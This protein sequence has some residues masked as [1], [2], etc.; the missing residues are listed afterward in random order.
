MIRIRAASRAL[1]LLIATGPIAAQEA[2][3]V[4]VDDS[5]TAE[6][7]LAQLPRL[8]AQESVAEAA[9]NIQKLLDD[10]PDRLV[11]DGD[12]PDLYQSVRERMHSALVGS[13][14][15]LERYR[16]TQEPRARKLLEEGR[17]DE[18]ERSFLMTR[19]GAEAALSLAE[20][21]FESA[22]FHAAMRTIAQLSAHPDIVADRDLSAR[23]ARLLVRLTP[24]AGGDESRRLALAFA[25]RAGIADEITPEAMRPI[26]APPSARLR[27]VG[28]SEQGPAFTPG[29]LLA[30]PLRSSPIAGPVSLADASLIRGQRL[31]SGEPRP[32][33]LPVLAGDVVLLNDGNRLTAWDRLTLERLWQYEPDANAMRSSIEV[34]GRFQR[35][36]GENEIRDATV[37]AAAG[38]VAVGVL[39]PSGSRA[40]NINPELHAVSL[41]SGEGIWSLVPSRLRSDWADAVFSGPPVIVE[42]T[43]VTGVFQFSPLRRVMSAYIA[44]IDLYTGELRWSSLVGTAGVAP[45]QRIEHTA[46]LITEREGIV[47]RTDPI[48]IVAA[49]EAHSGRPI[50]LRKVSVR[51]AFSGRSR[52]DWEQPAP[53]VTGDRLIALS[54][55][56]LEVQV[57]EASSG[58]LIG[59]RAA[60]LLGWPE[61]LL[62]FA[63][64]VICV[65]AE[66]TVVRAEGILSEEPATLKVSRAERAPG[67]VRLAGGTLM[68]PAHTGV[69]LVDPATPETP[70]RRISLDYPGAPIGVGDQLIIADNAFVHTYLPWTTAEASLRERMDASPDDP[71][72]ALTFAELA[73]RAGALELIPD[74]AGRALGAINRLGGSEKAGEARKR[75]YDSLIAMLTADIASSSTLAPAQEFNLGLRADLIDLLGQ[76]ARTPTERVGSLMEL[77]RLGEMQKQ[78]DEA[79]QAY[80][81]VLLDD[82]LATAQHIRGRHR[83]RAQLAATAAVRSIVHDHPRAYAAFDE[84]AASTLK[85]LT[86]E[87]SVADPASLET[88]AARYPVARV[89]PEALLT[90]S[91]LYLADGRVDRSISALER[92]L[93][94]METQNERR[95]PTDAI[96]GE[97]AGR[98]ISALAD[99]DRLF[100]ASQTLARLR[101]EHPTLKLTNMGN[102]LDGVQLADLFAQRLATLARLPHVDGPPVEIG[103]TFIGWDVMQ[104]LSTSGLVAT[105]HLVLYSRALG[106]MALFGMHSEPTEQLAFDADEVLGEAPGALRPIWSRSAPSGGEPVLLRLE[107]AWAILMWGRNETARLELIDTVTGRTRWQS[108][109]FGE[110]FDE[111]PERRRT[112]VVETPLDGPCRLSDLMIVFDDRSVAIVERTGRVAVF[113]LASGEA[114]WTQTLDVPVVYEA[115]LAGGVLALAGERPADIQAGDR[116]GVV[117]LLAV[118]DV[119]SRET[120]QLNDEL[121]S[122]LRWVRVDVSGD[123]IAGLDRGVISIEPRS[124][125][126]Q[127]LVDDP[128]VRLSGDAWLMHDRVVVLGPDPQIWQIDTRTGSLRDAPLEDLG[129]VGGSARIDAREGTAGETVFSTDHGLVVFNEHGAL[130]GGDATSGMTAVLPPVPGDG[131]YAMLQTEGRIHPDEGEIYRLWML[132]ARTG[133]IKGQADLHLLHG[134]E[135]LVLLDGAIIIGTDGATLVYPVR[136]ED[137][138]IR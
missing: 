76:S 93:A 126:T 56:Q 92:G 27:S 78:W 25:E 75:L 7:V 4:Y 32:W 83:Q 52:D 113:D 67:R 136:T 104:P 49:V 109:A 12:D 28:V 62:S 77:G 46:H 9:S 38:G 117:P 8:L 128:A 130:I 48:G 60:S 97:I 89:A 36:I 51:D 22:Q 116:P 70:Y 31:T 58:R 86:G 90:A 125:A 133:V 71:D 105:N 79:T 55:D 10:E 121:A 134:P 2:V 61:Y 13:P 87:G 5:P 96:A 29:E 33:T 98:L 47:Y 72:V 114:V 11:A 65:G 69:M 54:P 84:Q 91:N 19:S 101:S 37:V 45:S 103:Q 94:A 108:T 41:E 23:C 127:W 80:Q 21:E 135:S 120:L 138:V 40:E 81:A 3:P 111:E 68:I 57:F 59:E 124:G 24:Y 30:R 15:L 118:Y 26:E 53:V 42:G 100:A 129:R 39:I 106:Q 82:E 50:W 107:P 18:V 122:L 64:R 85:A 123:V 6:E 35:R 102:P 43:V 1:V 74:A 73:Y 66:I 34:P 17:F 99:H 14:A 20:Q 63:G 137:E 88:L 44:G 132:D 115:A 95:W 112:G 110:L 131:V 119:H 16:L